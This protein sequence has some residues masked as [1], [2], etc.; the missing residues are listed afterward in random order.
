MCPWSASL[1]PWEGDLDL[2]CKEFVLE[3][4]LSLEFPV[5][6]SCLTSSEDFTS[7]AIVV[8]PI[9]AVEELDGETIESSGF[10]FFASGSPLLQDELVD[11]VEVVL[12]EVKGEPE[13][14][15]GLVLGVV[16]TVCGSKVNV[17][18]SSGS[19]APS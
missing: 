4:E 7:W 6:F 17:I 2:L 14:F 19:F 10:G 16:E 12:W 1:I 13:V 11:F 5:I 18:V 15:F 8:V 9:L 3:S